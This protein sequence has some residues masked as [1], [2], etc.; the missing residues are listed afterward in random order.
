MRTFDNRRP[1]TELLIDNLCYKALTWIRRRSKQRGDFQRIVV[2]IDD[3]VGMR[4]IATGRFEL[5]QLDAIRTLLMRS[6]GTAS[7]GRNKRG[8]FLDIGANIGVYTLALSQFFDSTFAFEANPITH[9][10]LEVNVMLSNLQGVQ[11]ICKGVSNQ[12]RQAVL[13]MPSDGNL[14][15]ATLNRE[16]HSE[17]GEVA[18]INIELDTLDH[19]SSKFSFDTSPVSFIKID[20]EGHEAEVLQGAVG[21]LN[22]WKPIVVFEALNRDAAKECIKILSNSGYSQFCRFLRKR[23]SGSGGIKGYS[24]SVLRGLPIGFDEVDIDRPDRAPLICALH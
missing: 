17:G 1:L 24:E 19:L 3:V 8:T 18:P 10:I 20:V 14:G 9:K 12:P 6:E 22:R 4:I 23:T 13:Y 2:P 11:C 21:I 15:W 5:T 7:E 16:S